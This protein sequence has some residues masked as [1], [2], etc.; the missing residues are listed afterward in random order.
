MAAFGSPFFIALKVSRWLV[1]ADQESR[2]GENFCGRERQIYPGNCRSPDGV[3]RNP[4]AGFP[5]S[6]AFH[7]GYIIILASTGM[8][9]V[10]GS[11]NA[12]CTSVQ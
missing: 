5:N 11:G 10:A 12:A 1:A 4:V 8:T 2:F 9:G 6:T 7:P 3:E